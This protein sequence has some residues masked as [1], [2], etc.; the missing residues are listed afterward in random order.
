MTT[1]PLQDLLERHGGTGVTGGDSGNFT[2]QDLVDNMLPDQRDIVDLVIGA[3]VGN[4]D[5]SSDPSLVSKYY[6]LPVE[7]KNFIDFVVGNIVHEEETLAQAEKVESFL[8]HF[9]VKGMRWGVIRKSEASGARASARAKVRSGSATL[10]EAHQAAL[11]STGHR[12]TNAF[13][14]DKTYWKRTAIIAG[15]SAAGIA[16]SIAVPAVLPASVL[17]SVAAFAGGTGGVGG[18][19]LVNGSLASMA[20]LGQQILMSAG[21][22]TTALVAKGAAISNQVSNTRR[23]VFGNREIRK[24]MEGLGKLAADRQTAGTNRVKK[25]LNQSG[26]IRKRDLTHAEEMVEDFLAHFGVKGMKWGVR[27]SDAELSRARGGRK[28]KP[29]DNADS[30]GDGKKDTRLSADA[31]RFVRTTQKQGHEMSDR[32]IREA[33]NRA[34]MVKEYDEIFGQNKETGKLKAKVEKLRLEKDLRQ[35]EREVNPTA[36]DRAKALMDRASDAY[37]AYQ[38]LDKATDGKLS[39][40]LDEF[41]GRKGQVKVRDVTN[42]NSSRKKKGSSK[43]KSPVYNITTL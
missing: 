10:G 17:Q 8:A 9:G 21:V 34:K 30:D 25:I 6:A 26:S 27:R 1:T 18:Y 32:E 35:L 11:K 3:A 36:L 13:L 41:L 15:A 22:G 31:E 24:S 2:I 39:D 5:I 19:A 4:E 37:D 42:R 14:G 40:K 43:Q 12:V 16:A 23:A 33:L 29:T 38:R 7:H 20:T 28:S